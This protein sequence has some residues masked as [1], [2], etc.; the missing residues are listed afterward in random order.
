MDHPEGVAVRLGS[1]LESALGGRLEA[2]EAILGRRGGH[3]LLLEA[4]WEPEPLE[5]NALRV[6]PPAHPCTEENLN[7]VCW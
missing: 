2:S 1:V 5:F 6:T 4:Q 3:I 7:K